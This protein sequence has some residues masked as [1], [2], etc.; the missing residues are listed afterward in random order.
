LFIFSGNKGD[1]LIVEPIEEGNKVKAEIVQILTRDNIKFLKEEN[2]WPK[3]FDVDSSSAHAGIDEDLLPPAVESDDENNS[4][5]NFDNIENIPVNY[6]RNALF[7]IN[8]KP[9][10]NS[11]SKNADKA[12]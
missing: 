8:I 5:E 4:D 7:N 9:N 6:N 1:Y 12:V 11:N 2:L 10:N 3:G